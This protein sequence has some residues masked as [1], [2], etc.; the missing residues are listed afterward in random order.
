MPKKTKK[1]ASNDDN[2]PGFES[3]STPAPM[4]Q[5]LNSMKRSGGK[6]GGA[7]PNADDDLGRLDSDA[8]DVGAEDASVSNVDDK[9]DVRSDIVALMKEKKKRSRMVGGKRRRSASKKG[10]G[11]KKGSR[12]RRTSK[13]GGALRNKMM[14]CDVSDKARA[15]GRRQSRRSGKRPSRASRKVGR[16]ASRVR[17]RS[18]GRRIGGIGRGSRGRRSRSLRGRRSRTAG[19]KGNALAEFR[20]LA[21]HLVDNTPGLKLGPLAMT[22]ASIYKQAALKEDSTLDSISAMRRAKQLFDED[23]DA[24]RKKKLSDAVARLKDAREHR[25]PRK[26]KKKAA[27]SDEEVTD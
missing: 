4:G 16:I 8:S 27:E 19:G 17:S 14:A 20:K 23:T 10:K 5:F 15:V 1:G 2:E 25:K 9:S 18:Q 13:K 3:I 22:F 6:V 12:R 21:S 24:G 7:D 26:S 11:S